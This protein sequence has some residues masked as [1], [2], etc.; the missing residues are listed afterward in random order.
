MFYVYLLLQGFTKSTAS[1]SV[2]VYFAVVIKLLQRFLKEMSH[3]NLM[4]NLSERKIPT[5]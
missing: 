5:K 1:L 3:D 4:L 2:S